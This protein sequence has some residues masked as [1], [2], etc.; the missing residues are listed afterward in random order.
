MLAII[1][2]RKG[3]KGIKGKNTK[4]FNGKPLISWTIEVLQKSKK[5]DDIIVSTDDKKVV[6]IC[7]EYNIKIPFLRPKRLSADNSMSIDVYKYCINQFNQKSKKQINSFLVALPTSP[8]RNVQDVNK[9]IKIFEDSNPDSLISCKKNNHPHEWLLK[10][11]KKNIISKLFYETNKQNNYN[12]QTT[13]LTYLP[14][15]SIYIFNYKKLLKNNSFY[16]KNTLAYIMP[17]ERSVD[18]DNIN[19]FKYAEFLHKSLD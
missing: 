3:S 18:I 9:A 19:D 17:E 15:G 8:L 1:P 6:D 5:I 11:N 16:S 4:I 13:K 12:R 10:L 14:N 2:A 7:K